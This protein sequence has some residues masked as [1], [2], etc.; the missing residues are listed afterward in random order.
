M[1]KV[2]PVLLLV[3]FLACATG[4]GQNKEEPKPVIT[5]ETFFE[6]VKFLGNKKMEG[7]LPGTECAKKA[8][9]YIADK[10]KSYGIEPK[11]E[12]KTYFQKVTFTARGKEYKCRNVIGFIPGS[13][14][15]L[16]AEVIVVMGH[17]DH[18]GKGV[19]G[20]E[21]KYSGKICPGANDNA[22]G[23][24]G[25]IEVGRAI[26]KEGLKLKRS[27]LLL[28][29]TGEE[30]GLRGSQQ[31]VKKPAVALE[32][33]MA[34]INLDQIGGYERGVAAMGVHM[35]PQFDKGLDKAL[36]TEDLN[37]VR[38][39]IA[40]RGDNQCFNERYI[41]SIFFWTGFGDHYH[42]PT[43]T[44]DKINKEKGAAI[45]RLV[46][47]LVEY[48][49][50]EKEIESKLE[51]PRGSKKPYLGVSTDETAEGVIV[52]GIGKDTP[53]EKAGLKKGDVVSSVDGKRTDTYRDFTAALNAHKPG[54]KVKLKIQ[55]GEETK[56][57][58]VTLGER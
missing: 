58:E 19:Y 23:T 15:K 21:R 36:Q 53:A 47:R 7:R 11:G 18:V 3:L 35:S 17:Y 20:V 1:K 26:K 55:R 57:I 31:Y 48:L 41:P 2:M 29:T 46:V 43:D 13:D 45:C 22:S 27:V 32:K 38:Q 39:R 8:S 12:D 56:E 40:G 10:F 4:K 49:A 30:A 44:V 9:Q 52:T 50:N 14:E 24:A 16:K 28:T 51:K 25:V 42:K 54:D 33:T 34:V 5:A 6:H 37:V